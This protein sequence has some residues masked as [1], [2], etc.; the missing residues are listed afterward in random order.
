VRGVGSAQKNGAGTLTLSGDVDSDG[1]WYVSAG[2]L[3][4]ANATASVGEVAVRNLAGC[5]F[6]GIGHVDG[7]V[8]VPGAATLVLGAPGAGG[9]LDVGGTVAFGEGATV[10]VNGADGAMGACSAA[11]WSLPS[12]LSIK[13][14]SRSSVA[15]P[16]FTCPTGFGNVDFSNWTV[17]RPNGET[18][19]SAATLSLSGD[20]KTISLS[21]AGPFVIMVR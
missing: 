9:T 7:S 6:G 13:P 3:L 20:G 11:A 16:L 8:G 2:G 18:V 10:V 4:L 12:A 19:N 14:Q 21:L 15:T 1:F 17:Y 5:L